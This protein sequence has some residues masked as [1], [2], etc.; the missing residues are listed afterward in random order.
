MA[1]KARK[2]E[3]QR[4][5]RKQ[6]QQARRRALAISPYQR[7]ATTGEVELCL[8]GDDWKER[9][10][11]I[12]F[13]LH[14]TPGGGHAMA[15][16][17]VDLWC[18]GLKDAWGHVHVS[19]DEFDDVVD[20]MSDD[21]TFSE[22]DLQ[23]ARRLVA[24]GL[25]FAFQNG[26][27]L[28]AHYE[29]WTAMLGDL[30]DWKSADISDFGWEGGKLYWCAPLSDLR[31]RLVGSTVQ[32]F[33]ARP[34][35]EYTAE[36]EAEPEDLDAEMDEDDEEDDELPIEL[37][38][39]AG[40]VDDLQ[41]NAADAVRRWCFATGRQPHARLGDGLDV[42]FAAMAETAAASDP[43][44]PDED[45]Q[46]AAHENVQKLLSLS[47]PEDAAEIAAAIDQLSEYM[48]QF[49]NPQDALEAMGLGGL[50]D[51][52]EPEDNA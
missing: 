40:A 8:L 36:I 15:T 49:A 24:G 35:V 48:K 23:T 16:F 33:L 20:Q 52:D 26:F 37:E 51:D 21:L 13:V 7:I 9:G 5:K 34:D 2:K 6:K 30:G 29:R 3:K 45:T 44:G 27:R 50:P 43:L 31:K 28:P 14:S 22:T 25:R 11:A 12:V 18:A 46:A 4:L 38:E 41:R 47:P 10:Q 17:L 39:L 19:R 42:L 32:E 1:D